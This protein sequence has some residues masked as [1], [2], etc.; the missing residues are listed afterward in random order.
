MPLEVNAII[1]QYFSKDLA[2]TLSGFSQTPSDKLFNAV[3]FSSLAAVHQLKLRL[4]NASGAEMAYRMAK[5]A[6]GTEVLK[7]LPA[8]Y[9]KHSHYQGIINMTSILYNGDLSKIEAMLEER[10]GLSTDVANRVLIM[11]TCATLAIFGERVKS[12]RIRL[13]GF[14][15]MVDQKLPVFTDVLA[16]GVDF[17]FIHWETRQAELRNQ[18]F[19]SE[20][21]KKRPTEK[22]SRFS[23]SFKWLFATLLS[24]GILSYI[25]IA[26]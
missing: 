19:K 22:K 10:F 8:Y 3:R 23:L 14:R 18:L 4:Q 25:F 21:R 13:E 12:K 1:N 9:N 11:S 6:G 5:V 17:P 2:E 16:S 26:A 15:E 7:H 20:S 24:V